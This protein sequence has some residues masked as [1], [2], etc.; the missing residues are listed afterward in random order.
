VLTIPEHLAE[1]GVPGR[2]SPPDYGQELARR[3]QEATA[4][5]GQGAAEGP[6]R[7]AVQRR[8]AAS[9]EELDWVADVL[10]PSELEGESADSFRT[11]YR[12][13]YRTD[14][15]HYALAELDLVLR[16]A[17]HALLTT[18]S[19]GTSHGSPY[20]Y[21]RWVPFVLLG[22]GVEPGRSD[23]PVWTVD[24]A[25]SLAAL[26]GIAFPDDLDGAPRGGGG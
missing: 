10:L 26:A 17:E 12:N 2:R 19:H 16:P 14:R 9:L 13:S 24:L 8:V 5:E 15:R 20:W 23:E 18:S 7:E 6:E 3:V 22:P 4:A 11:L 1:T 25:P 21:D